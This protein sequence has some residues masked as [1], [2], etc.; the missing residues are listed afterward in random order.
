MSVEAYLEEPAISDDI[1]ELLGENI[2]TLLFDLPDDELDDADLDTE[3]IT[4]TKNKQY[5]SLDKDDSSTPHS[6]RDQETLFKELMQEHQKRLYRFVIRY[7][8]QPDDAADITQQAFVE[9][10]RTIRCFRGESKLSTWLYGIAM[11]MVRNYLSRSPHRLYRFESDEILGGL[12]CTEPDPSDSF[13]QRELLALVDGAFS[14]LPAEMREVLSLVAIDEIS[15]QDAAEILAIPL[16][17][18]RSRV[19]RARTVLRT[20]FIQAGVIIK[21]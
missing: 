12:A 3:L 13:E 14:G 20:H 21:F 7:I 11:N 9:A 5:H 17:T 6:E 15:Y 2:D 19:S 8:D 4:D 18:V 1:N 10:A 16:G